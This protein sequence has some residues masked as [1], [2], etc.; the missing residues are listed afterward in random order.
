MLA[1]LHLILFVNGL[2][3]RAKIEQL[4]FKPSA[5]ICKWILHLT[6]QIF[7]L[8]PRTSVLHR[9]KDQV[10][11]IVGFLAYSPLLVV[12]LASTVSVAFQQRA[13]ICCKHAIHLLTARHSMLKFTLHMIDVDFKVF[14]EGEHFL[15][16]IMKT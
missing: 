13:F 9:V 1:A 12:L 14:Q 5:H 4:K 8:I 7:K 15:S 3:D 16:C 10:L 6:R 11:I 2:Q